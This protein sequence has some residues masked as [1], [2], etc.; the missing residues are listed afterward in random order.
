MIGGTGIDYDFIL[1]PDPDQVIAGYR[2]LTGDAPLMPRWSWGFWRSA[3]TFRPRNG[4]SE[5]RAPMNVQ[6][7]FRSMS[8]VMDWR[9]WSPGQ[10]G[11]FRFDRAPFPHP[12]AMMRDL[13][14]MHVHMP[15]SVWARFDVG[16]ANEQAFDKAG[17]L[18]ATSRMSIR[19]A[20]AAGTTLEPA[21]AR[22][23]ANLIRQNY[24]TLGF[25]AWSLDASEPELGGNWG[26]LAQLQTTTGPGAGSV[27]SWYPPAA[28]ER[29][30]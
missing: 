21:R 26:E 23:S 13:A 5:S 11:S 14:A 18:F 4:H 15:V 6:W 25:D 9:H 24:T 8:I 12:T 3:R 19:P 29:S 30:P 27:Q 1:G 22:R 16:T 20:K 28:H 10:W 2:W 17:G 7:A